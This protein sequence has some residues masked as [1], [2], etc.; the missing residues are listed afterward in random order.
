MYMHNHFFLKKAWKTRYL[1]KQFISVDWMSQF[2]PQLKFLNELD[3]RFLTMGYH[4]VKEGRRFLF[5]HN[6]A[7]VIS[8]FNIAVIFSK[9]AH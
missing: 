4:F 5:E 3:V 6:A 9:R 7:G 2:F 8:K 1:C